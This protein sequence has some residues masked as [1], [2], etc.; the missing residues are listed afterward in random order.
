MPTTLVFKELDKPKESYVLFRGEYDQRREPAES[1]NT[2]FV[3]VN[4]LENRRPIGSVWPNGWSTPNTRLPH[5]L[6]SIVFG[7]SCLAQASSK[8]PRTSDHKGN[9]PAIGS[10]SIGWRSSSSSRAGMSNS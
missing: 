9:R 4:H 2:R 5:A 3:A 1:A 8:P 7:N 6:P 10:C